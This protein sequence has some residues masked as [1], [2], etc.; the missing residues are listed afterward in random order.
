M[1]VIPDITV[2]DGQNGAVEDVASNS[3]IVVNLQP[4]GSVSPNLINKLH[5]PFAIAYGMDWMK[6]D[7]LM[8]KL[9]SSQSISTSSISEVLVW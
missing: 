3:K 1:N 9:I 2:G 7:H 5:K 6:L 4:D 8:L